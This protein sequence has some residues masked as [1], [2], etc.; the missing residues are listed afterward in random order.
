VVV[1]T[2][3]LGREVDSDVSC[4]VVISVEGRSVRKQL[5]KFRF[6]NDHTLHPHTK[7]LIITTSKTTQYKVL[8]SC[9]VSQSTENDQ[10]TLRC[11]ETYHL[12]S[13]WTIYILPSRLH[14]MDWRVQR[15]YKIVLLLAAGTR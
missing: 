1:A 7:Q 8:F 12:K 5:T 13:A 14:L 11:L 6:A 4:K 10:L 9:Q 2:G 15:K 3:V